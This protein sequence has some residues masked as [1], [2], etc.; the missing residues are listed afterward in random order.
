MVALASF[1]FPLVATRM[2]GMAAR[3]SARLNA[4]TSLSPP[5]VLTV[6]ERYFMGLPSS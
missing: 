1:H 6:M 3:I 2:G 5:G 4:L